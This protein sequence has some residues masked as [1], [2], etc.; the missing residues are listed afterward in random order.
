MLEFNTAL[1][2]D[3]LV[4]E[5]EGALDSNSAADFRTW[6]NEK[7]RVGFRAFAL[8]CL[9]LEYISSA[10]ISALIDL[11]NQLKVQ[12][13]KLVLYQLSSETRQLLRFL[14]IDAK[15]NLCSDY[16]AAL[17]MLTGIKRVE[18]E[19]LSTPPATENGGVAMVGVEELRVLEQT[20]SIASTTPVQPAE[21][22]PIH[23]H[24]PNEVVV[25]EQLT[26]EKRGLHP[27]QET[28]AAVDVQ[29]S[30]TENKIDIGVNPTHAT[31]L[32]EKEG[33]PPTAPVDWEETPV[34]EAQELKIDAA[35]KR[36]ITCPNCRNVLRLSVPGDY[37]CPSC[38]FRF[39][40]KG[41]SAT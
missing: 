31:T 6:F 34:R 19:N 5:L 22:P 10:G 29:T 28:S 3:I 30:T 18:K 12:N 23:E 27:I 1:T 7:I 38:R 11:Q 13:G 37:L 2:E 4:I 21:T 26:Q 20:E 14:Q 41:S 25:E 33:A 16:D 39:T 17:Q 32:A 35:A 9:C 8:D 15:L 36:L 24:N 40:Y